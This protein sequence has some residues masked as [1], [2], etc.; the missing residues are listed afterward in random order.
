MANPFSLGNIPCDVASGCGCGGILPCSPCDLPEQDLVLT[1]TGTVYVLPY[2]T[3]CT[4]ST[5]TAFSGAYPLNYVSPSVGW[6]T[7]CINYSSYPS[8]WQTIDNY[9][10]WIFT[11]KCT[12]NLI[13]LNV[14][15]YNGSSTFV[16]QCTIGFLACSSNPIGGGSGG[17]V[18]SSVDSSCSPLNLVYNINAF[19]G[20]SSLP[21]YCS[22][23]GAFPPGY[24]PSAAFTQIT[25]TP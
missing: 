20:L 22:L 4:P 11:F 3:A 18:Y 8:I 21:G 2:P 10:S 9:A 15:Q 6:V 1:L 24:F 25:I 17:L 19:C 14:Y 23:G 5:P 12:S 16:S 7:P 13:G